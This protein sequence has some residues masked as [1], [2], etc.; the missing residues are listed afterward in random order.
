M[1]LPCPDWHVATCRP[2][3]LSLQRI[4]ACQLPGV[5][6]QLLAALPAVWYLDPHAGSPAQPAGVLLLSVHL[7]TAIQAAGL[8]VPRLRNG[9]GLQRAL[10][11]V[12]Q[13]RQTGQVLQHRDWVRRAES[14]IC[15]HPHLHVPSWDSG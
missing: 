13:C 11:V 2:S 6:S 14:T 7:P 4:A 10:R 12:V 8:Q 1:A 15:E 9:L 5:D 3:L